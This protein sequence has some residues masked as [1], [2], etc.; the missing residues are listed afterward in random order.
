MPPPRIANVGNGK[1]RSL[2]DEFVEREQ[3]RRRERRRGGGREGGKAQGTSVWTLAYMKVLVTFLPSRW[4]GTH[5]STPY[6]VRA[7]EI[8]P[9]IHM[10]TWHPP[11]KGP[12]LIIS[13]ISLHAKMADEHTKCASRAEKE[14]GTTRYVGTRYVRCSARVFV[15]RTSYVRIFCIASPWKNMSKVYLALGGAKPCLPAT[16]SAGAPRVSS[17]YE[18]TGTPGESVSHACERWA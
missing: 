4:L 10:A 16:E 6:F 12:W 2:P 14:A 9:S 3:E 8:P 7:F 11:R 1:A 18:R 17:W 15:L 5:C 13:Y